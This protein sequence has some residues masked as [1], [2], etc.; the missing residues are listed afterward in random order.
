MPRDPD[1]VSEIEQLTD[2]EIERRH[3][4]LTNVD[5]DLRTAVRQYEKSGLPERSDRQ[6]AT[7]RDVDPFASSAFIASAVGVDEF[8]DGVA[9]GERMRIRVDPEP[10]S[11]RGSRGVARSVRLEMT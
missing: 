11:W 5:L 9:P 8:R 7:A 4:V 3:R 10:A 1:P 6:D 2:L